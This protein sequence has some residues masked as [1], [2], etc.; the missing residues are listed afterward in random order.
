LIRTFV[1]D[2]SR[3]DYCLT[4]GAKNQYLIRQFTANQLIK[5]PRSM[6]W[7]FTEHEDLA[8]QGSG[9]YVCNG[10]S[11]MRTQRIYAFSK[12]D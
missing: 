6:G 9:K 4:T 12:D 5:I 2:E 8:T 10:E 11:I 7:K 3:E 1:G